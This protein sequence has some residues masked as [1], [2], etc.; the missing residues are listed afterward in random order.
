MKEN[1]FLLSSD[2]EGK[3]KARNLYN[4]LITS[5]PYL[6]IICE[7]FRSNIRNYSD[8]IKKYCVKM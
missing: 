3:K 5:E 4:S 7:N 2:R 6:F 1:F 8:Y